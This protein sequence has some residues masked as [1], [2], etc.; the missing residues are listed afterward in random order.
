MT[1]REEDAILKTSIDNG[2]L[3]PMGYG[4][5]SVT[6]AIW[7]VPEGSA[8]PIAGSIT[9]HILNDEQV[10]D[11]PALGEQM[12]EGTIAAIAGNP[13]VTFIFKDVEAIDRHIANLVELKEHIINVT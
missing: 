9:I 4:L 12:P 11:G 1:P 6:S 2:N 5:V 3:V 7:T 13:N 8:Y 10:T